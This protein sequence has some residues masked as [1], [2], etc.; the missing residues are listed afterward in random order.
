[1]SL[2][3]VVWLKVGWGPLIA[4]SLWYLCLGGTWDHKEEEVELPTLCIWKEN[5]PGFSY[6]TAGNYWLMFFIQ[7]EIFLARDM[8]GDFF[9][10]QN[11]S[12]L[13]IM[14]W[15]STSSLNLLPP[16]TSSNTSPASEQWL[17]ACHT[18][19]EVQIQVLYLRSCWHP[20]WRSSLKLG[21]ARIPRGQGL[22]KAPVAGWGKSLVFTH[23][24]ST[25]TLQD[26]SLPAQR[27][28]GL[29]VLSSVSI[30]LAEVSGSF[31]EAHESESLIPA[32]SF[33]WHVWSQFP[34]W[35]LGRAE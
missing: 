21:R 9:F 1:M 2:S 15:D 23:S 34:L 16:L 33:C 14:S 20:I 26:A 17:P 27:H 35:Y 24:L 12:F 11:L 4:Y 7:F 29:P 18:C 8:S 31:L 30:T 3:I 25:D 32:L 10:N 13:C 6:L 19:T 28:G 22:D 5:S